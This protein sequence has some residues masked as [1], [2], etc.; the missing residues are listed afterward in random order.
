MGYSRQEYWSEQPFHPPGDLPNPEVEPTSHA[1]PALQADSLP[2]SHQGSPFVIHIH[3][4]I[5]TTIKLINISITSHSYLSSF[6]WERLRSVCSLGRFQIYHTVLLTLVTTLHLK[7][8]DLFILCNWNLGPFSQQL[9]N[10]PLPSSPV[11]DKHY[12]KL[13]FYEL[14]CS[15]FCM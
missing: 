7:S 14:D 6:V 1:S 9:P 4:E 5:L 2:L 10:P 12:S 8:P 15:S 13:C 3:C 11:L